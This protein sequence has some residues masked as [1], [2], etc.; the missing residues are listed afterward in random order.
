VSEPHVS[1]LFVCLGNI[2]R[3]PTAE[4]IFCA[5]AKAR[6]LLDRIHVDSA[7][8]GSWHVG[9]P[10]DPRARREAQRRG[11][12][13]S[14]IRGRTVSK[15]DFDRFDYVLAMDRSNLDALTRLRP[16][17]CHGRL[18][19]ISDFS[20][21]HRG[22]EVPD[23]YFGGEDGFKAVYAML[24]ACVAGLLDTIESSRATDVRKR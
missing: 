5:Q 20:D 1:V 16:A 2:C 24:E 6:G 7:G 4:G 21:D 10:P 23:P 3:S 19:L 8:T 17:S 9:E 12:D 14:G 15:R 18:S 22:Q 13:I 11:I